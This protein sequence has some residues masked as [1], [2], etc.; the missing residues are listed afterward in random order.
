[1]GLF[2]AVKQRNVAVVDRLIMAQAQVNA[3]DHDS[4]TPIFFCV[5]EEDQ[6]DVLQKLL[7]HGAD[8]EVRDSRGDSPIGNAK[9]S[10]KRKNIQAFIAS[11]KKRRVKCKL[12]GN[13]TDKQWEVSLKSMEKLDGRLESCVIT[14]TD[15]ENPDDILPYGSELYKAEFETLK[16]DNPTLLALLE[17]PEGTPWTTGPPELPVEKTA[18][19]PDV[20][21]SVSWESESPLEFEIAA[22]S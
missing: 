10:K 12:L 5:D 4:R 2:Q 6:N 9:Q 16:R 18:K 7:D 8:I 1:M 21:A 13:K 15:K 17:Y 11:L 19:T 14:F 20:D 22:R 3:R